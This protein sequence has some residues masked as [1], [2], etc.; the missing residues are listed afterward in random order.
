MRYVLGLD[1][2]IQSVGWAVVRCDEPAVLKILVCGYLT[3]R[4]PKIQRQRQS[5]PAGNSGL[6]GGYF[7]AG[8]PERDAEKTF[9]ENRSASRREVEALLSLVGRPAAAAC[10]G[11]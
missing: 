3:H 11:L 1:V 5:E 7:A 10:Q 8:P 6:Q 4:K 9:G 2:G